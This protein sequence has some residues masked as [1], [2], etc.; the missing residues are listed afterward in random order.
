MKL[1]LF[2]IILLLTPAAFAATKYY[3]VSDNNGNGAYKVCTN[4]TP[5]SAIPPDGT[6]ISLTEYNSTRFN[7]SV[8]S[9]VSCSTGQYEAMFFRINL[10]NSAPTNALNISLRAKGDNLGG[11][12]T[13]YK[14]FLRNWTSG[15]YD[16]VADTGSNINFV[17]FNISTTA[18]S[19][20]VNS[21]NFIVA[22]VI[23]RG[24]VGGGGGSP[25]IYTQEG[26]RGEVLSYS[27]FP[28]L[29]DTDYLQFE[30]SHPF[31]IIN[32]EFPEEESVIK[33][34]K[35]YSLENAKE[36]G[37]ELVFE[38]RMK[39][40][41]LDVIM[42]ALFDNI[43]YN[44][45]NILLS[46]TPKEVF[47]RSMEKDMGLK[48]TDS[49]EEHFVRVKGNPIHSDMYQT[50][51]LPINGDYKIEYN[52]D[53]LEIK[54]VREETAYSYSKRELE[55]DFQPFTITNPEKKIINFQKGS[56]KYLLEITG[57]YI[58][59]AYQK[60]KDPV[61]SIVWFSVNIMPKIGKG[62]W[63]NE[64]LGEDLKS[65]RTL[66]VDFFRT[67]VSYTQGADNIAPTIKLVSPTT[68]QVIDTGV[69]INFNFN[70]T[71]PNGVPKCSL[72]LDGIERAS[73]QNP[74]EFFNE[75]IGYTF[76]QGG[77]FSANIR[78]LDEAGNLGQSISINI[79]VNA[80]ILTTFIEVPPAGSTTVINQNTS[81][82]VT[83]NVTCLDVPCSEVVL[84]LRYNDS[85]NEPNRNVYPARRTLSIQTPFE[86]LNFT[87]NITT[88]AA[89]SCTHPP[90][91]TSLG[92]AFNGTDM[93]LRDQS[94]SLGIVHK[95]RDTCT[96]PSNFTSDIDITYLAVDKG[97]NLYT[98]EPNAVLGIRFIHKLNTNLGFLN[99][100]CNTGTSCVLDNFTLSGFTA[101]ITGMDFDRGGFLWVLEGNTKLK[102][103]N[104]SRG[105]TTGDCT[106]GNG[107]I[108]S[109]MDLDRPVTELSIIGP[110]AFLTSDVGSKYYKIMQ[111]GSTVPV[112]ET[113]VADMRNIEFNGT[114]FWVSSISDI[115]KIYPAEGVSCGTLS[116]NKSCQVNWTI[117]ATG[118]TGTAWYIDA[119][120]STTGAVNDTPN[121]RLEIGFVPASESDGRQ[122]IEDGINSA[123]PG[124]DILTSHQLYVVNKSGSQNKGLF[125][126]MAIKNN[127][128][129]AFNYITSGESSTNIP[130][131]LRTVNIWENQ[132][133]TK[134]QIRSQV[135]TFINQTKG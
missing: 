13:G 109:S 35:I 14:I 103:L 88:N 46:F 115:L 81:F 89:S 47:F 62:E 118:N 5:S 132:S 17:M 28:S 123:I 96:L 58:P 44:T 98:F 116:V 57:Y 20:Y 74:D 85:G 10:T 18:T 40:K 110:S 22:Q 54:N 2:L 130:S 32:E 134:A 113:G 70:Y 73:I 86:I 106:T 27:I 26:F 94:G 93:L 43:D 99:G 25:S 30:T 4:V 59:H 65:H 8:T 133:L 51:R 121:V 79:T 126:K 6:E 68:N 63:V 84:K 119:L 87:G 83:A 69:R 120:S 61:E 108:V 21:S 71:E 19:N 77:K 117:N 76:N 1:H 82:H 11:N 38:G 127:Q 124:S 101:D 50:Y 31:I 12:G 131:L 39:L 66:G 129:W 60:K 125:D 72:F 9:D 67:N 112:L 24:T 75:S 135:E 16:Q 33:S 97:N 92:L 53:L 42:H 15:S 91:S 29:E 52:S 128:T 100:N 34:I 55:T 23:T 102:K 122:A 90:L 45:I 78:C 105:E 41:P 36:S 64:V 95:L 114:H 80:P 49:D 107:C 3:K 104:M 37:K 7:E 111:N 56:G 48:I